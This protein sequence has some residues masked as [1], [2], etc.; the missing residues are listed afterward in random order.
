MET[1]IDKL[2]DDWI[3]TFEQND[4]LY[5]DFYKD[6]LYFTH[7]H[8]IYVN[9]TDEIEKIKQ[10]T[11][12]MSLPNYVTRDEVIGILKKNS[13]D[14]N[15]RYSLLAILKYNITINTEDIEYFLKN[16]DLETYSKQF[17]T[18]VRNIDAIQFEK[19]IS[20]FHD[21][22]DLLFIFYEKSTEIKKRDDNNA[23]RKIILNPNNHKKTIKK[24]YKD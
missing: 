6:D 16:N 17:L 12:L 23:T 19:T 14:N 1:E 20:M 10:E 15:R 24:Q 21:L 13:I 8:L 11:F 9:R 2:D 5:K 7:L 3:N 22:N 18:I 4:K